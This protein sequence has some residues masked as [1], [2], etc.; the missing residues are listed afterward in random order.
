MGELTRAVFNKLLSTSDIAIGFVDLEGV[1][2]DVNEAF[3]KITKYSREEIIH[4]KT[5]RDITPQ[6]Y[7]DLETDIVKELLATENP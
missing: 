2:I 3:L 7:F 1:F 6:E 4:E 5:F